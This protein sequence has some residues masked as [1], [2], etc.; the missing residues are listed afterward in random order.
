V[1]TN[2]LAGESDKECIDNE[3]ID[4]KIQNMTLN[5]RVESKVQMEF[6][7]VHSGEVTYIYKPQT[8]II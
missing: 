1:Y 6:I 3:V 4:V 7:V 8:I 5:S 2:E